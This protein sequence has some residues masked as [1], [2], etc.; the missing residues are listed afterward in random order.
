ME[1][2]KKYQILNFTYTS[3]DKSD[4]KYK[5]ESYDYEHKYIISKSSYQDGLKYLNEEIS[6][7][8]YIYIYYKLDK[9]IN[10][11]EKDYV[12]VNEK[13]LNDLDCEDDLLRHF[14]VYLESGGKHFIYT[15]DNKI[16]EIIDKN[17]VENKDNNICKSEEEQSEEEEEKD[18]K[19]IKSK[20]K[21]KKNKDDD[22]SEENKLKSLILLY[23]Y[24]KHI[25]KL[26]D[27]PIVDEY[28]FKDYYL[29][30]MDFIIKYQNLHTFIFIINL[31]K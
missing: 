1:K 9:I 27:S 3:T 19:N 25:Q 8:P 17:F 14:V 22:N 7:P 23:A 28:E 26:L 4:M 13:F 2:D 15:E 30:D 11:I 12:L 29:I 5:F 18:K 20:K 10:N 21:G 16:L 31:I 24:E 6:K